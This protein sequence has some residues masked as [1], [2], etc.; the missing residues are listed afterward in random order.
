MGSFSYTPR[1][2]ICVFVQRIWGI[3]LTRPVL[4]CCLVVW[5]VVIFCYTRAEMETVEV[6]LGGLAE[7]SLKRPVLESVSSFGGWGVS[8]TR[9][10]LESVLWFV[11]TGVSYTLCLVVKRIRS[12][13][14]TSRVAVILS[15]RS[16]GTESLS[17]APC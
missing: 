7:S 11:G 9:P 12:F 1:D 3:S 5:F 4:V 17:H 6:R 13:S 8:L 10:V 14:D 2:G 15:R 16:S